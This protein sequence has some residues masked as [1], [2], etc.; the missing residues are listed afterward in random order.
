MIGE[1]NEE[2]LRD[3][4]IFDLT[5]DDGEKTIAVDGV[6]ETGWK[7]V[8]VLDKRKVFAHLYRQLFIF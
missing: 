6:G 1:I 7:L 5:T 2:G 3:K 4:N 8:A